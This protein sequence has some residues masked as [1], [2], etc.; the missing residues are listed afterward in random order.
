M[1]LGTKAGKTLPGGNAKLATEGNAPAASGSAAPFPSMFASGSFSGADIKVVLHYPVNKTTAQRE[2]ARLTERKEELQEE[3]E[4]LRAAD[5]TDPSSRYYKASALVIK[6]VY[7]KEEAIKVINQRLDYFN[8][9]GSGL[10][11]TVAAT[12]TLADLQTISWSIHRAKAPIRT[13][14]AVYPRSIVRGNRTIAGTMI[15][16]MFDRS[17]L[18]DFL[19]L[20]LNPYNTGTQSDRDYYHDTTALID[21]LPPLDMTIIAS[22]EYGQTSYMNLWGVDFLNDG[23]TFSIE[24]LFTETVVNYMARDIDL[25]RPTIGR[26]DNVWLNSITGK[27]RRLYATELITST[28]KRRNPYI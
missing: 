20:G 16:T 13:L 6:L 8:Y 21:Q 11:G 19:S 5:W 24:D 14:G 4:V 3:V 12:K 7:E 23:G 2:I 27:Q 10:S 28:E 1:A 15:F 17:A 26:D 9:A 25:L 22:N 18:Y